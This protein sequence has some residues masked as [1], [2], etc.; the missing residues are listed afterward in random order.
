MVKAGDEIVA[1]LRVIDTPGHT[2]GHVSFE[3]T[4]G[5]GLVVGGDVLTHPL[6]SFQYPECRDTGALTLPRHRIY[7]RAC[8]EDLNWA[9]PL[10][11]GK[12]I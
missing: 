6:I 9:R 2:Q 11:P 3:L 5:E 12:S 7:T 4:G 10:D 8:P 1:G